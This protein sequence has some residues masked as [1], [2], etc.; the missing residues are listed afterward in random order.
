MDGGTL[1]LL[2]ERISAKF[3]IGPY[4]DF[5]SAMNDPNRRKTFHGEISKSMNIGTFEEFERKILGDTTPAVKT[6]TITFEKTPEDKIPTKQCSDF[7]FQLGCIN[8]KIGDFN[9]TVFRGDRYNDTYT[10]RVQ[11]HLD[12][13]SWFTKEN[14]NKEL[15][16]DI[17]DEF[18]NKSV[19]KESI[20]KVLKEYINKKK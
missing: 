1:R 5:K 10:T 6:R 15:T 4:E 12:R 20:K 3:N 9:A 17:W 8:P 19:I 14:Q 2:W 13:L 7:P 11:T 16:Q 18:M